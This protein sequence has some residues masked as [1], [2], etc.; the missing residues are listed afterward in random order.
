METFC[1]IALRSLSTVLCF[2]VDLLDLFCAKLVI[3]TLIGKANTGNLQGLVADSVSKSVMLR[4]PRFHYPFWMHNSSFSFFFKLLQRVLNEGWIFLCYSTTFK[5]M[6]GSFYCCYFYTGFNKKEGNGKLGR[7]D[8]YFC[9]KGRKIHTRD[10]RSGL[11]DILAAES[12][13]RTDLTAVK[14]CWK[15]QTLR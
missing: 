11:V 8:R 15:C 9:E 12:Q 4:S 10:S 14:C 5:S 1:I 7:N 6:F 2:F 3:Y 13:K